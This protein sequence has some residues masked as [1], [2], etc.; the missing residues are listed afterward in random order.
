[1]K[2]LRP[3]ALAAVV[4]TLLVSL[5][6]CFGLPSITGGGTTATDTS[7]AGTTWGGTDSDGDVWLMD[8]QADNTVGFTYNDS[9]FDDA[10]DTWALSGGQLTIVIEFTDGTSTMTGPYSDGASTIDLDGVQGDAT[11]TL[12]LTKE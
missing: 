9:Q 12:T 3:A 10:T 4:L 5:T 2:T 1:M 11:W 7:L 6:G 8:F